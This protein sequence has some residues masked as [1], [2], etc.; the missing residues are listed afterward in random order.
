MGRMKIQT[1]QHTYSSPPYLAEK[2]GVQAF[3]LLC[4]GKTAG[5]SGVR[6][7]YRSDPDMSNFL[8]L[9]SVFR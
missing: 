2:Q 8:F 1:R 6:R 9:T 3:S 5:F 7:T 4:L